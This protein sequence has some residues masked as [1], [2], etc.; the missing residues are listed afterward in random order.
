[1][2]S[3]SPSQIMPPGSLHKG[4]IINGFCEPPQGSL[5]MQTLV[6]T[7]VECIRGL[8]ISHENI[9]YPL[10]CISS[11]MLRNTQSFPTGLFCFMEEWECVSPNS[12]RL[13]FKYLL[14]LTLQKTPHLCVCV[15]LHRCKHACVTHPLRGDLKVLCSSTTKYWIVLREHCTDVCSSIRGLSS[16][17]SHDSLHTLCP[18]DR[19]PCRSTFCLLGLSFLCRLSDHVLS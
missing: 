5:H 15:T 19:G 11:G 2:Y 17:F 12:C 13:V 18:V 1:M 14:V 10:Q 7:L 9:Q 16:L 4:T 3:K 6:S 8:F